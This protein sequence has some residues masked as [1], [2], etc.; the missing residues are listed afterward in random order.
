MEKN[1]QEEI[2]QMPETYRVALA[3]NP[4]VGKSTVFNALTGL[5]QHTGNWAGKTV[6]NAEGTA[7]FREKHYVLYDLPG[8]YSLRANSA[9]EEAARDFLCKGAYDAAIVVCDACCLE[10]NLNLVLQVMELSPRVLVCVNLLDEAEKRGISVDFAHLEKLLGA[11]VVGMSARSGSGLTQ[12]LERLEDLLQA[13]A[14]AHFQP[15]YGEILEPQLK[16]LTDLLA[17]STD[18]PPRWAALRLLEGDAS[19]RQWIPA[20]RLLPCFPEHFVEIQQQLASQGL[21]EERVQDAVIAALVRQAESIAAQ[22]VSTVTPETDARD[23]RIDSVLTSR[24]FGIPVMLLLLLGILWL[25]MAGANY[26]SALLSKWL[27]SVE[28]AASEALQSAGAPEWVEGL[29]IH[30]MFRTLSWVVSVM[31]PPM[32]IFFPL[33]TLL[34]DAGYL[35]R[36]AFNLDNRFRKCGACG[37]QALTM[38]MGFGCNAVGVTGCRII[39]APRE[40]CIAMLT[41]SLVPCNGRFPLFISLISMFFLTGIGAVDSF[42]SA[43][44]L[45]CVI[46]L[47]VGMT[48]LLSFILSRTVLRGMPSSFTL[49][50]PPYRRPQFGKVIVRSVLDRTLH[51][52]GRACITAAPTGLVLWLLANCHVENLSLLQHISAF[53][54]PFAHCFGLDGVILLAFILAFPANEIV[55]PIMIMTYL[56]QGSLTE[57]PE[58]S[59][60]HSLLVENGWTM[61]TALCTMLFSLFH[62]PCATTVLTIRKET[63]SWK[64]AFFAMLLPTATGLCLCFLVNLA[65]TLL[66]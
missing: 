8:T 29:F 65:A 48:F 59:T 18:L 53:L 62:F 9:E 5:H 58:L 37:K 36:V 39:D 41:N 23:R 64:W 6:T 51:V 47:G 33:F 3:G 20:Q 45:F 55:I 2:Q 12:M 42:L 34:E 21:S 11:P 63:N 10:R 43:F 7:E 46:L 28:T 24:K 56:A 44:C 49:E 60:L 26:P 19:V 31:L 50:L 1:A 66:A 14:P 15:D 4:N 30:G 32:A 16:I 27:F 22:T 61:T 13:P 57:V 54:D 40:R 25:T 38:C 17:G 35:P 52:L